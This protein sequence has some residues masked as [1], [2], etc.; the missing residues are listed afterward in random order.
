LKYEAWERELS[1]EDPDREFILSGIR[2]G[3]SIIDK[4]VDIVPVELS[5]HKSVDKHSHLYNEVNKQVLKELENNN[6]VVCDS[7]PLIVSPLG[8]IPKDNNAVRLIHDCSLPCGGAVND[9]ASDPDKYSFETMDNVAKLIKPG[10][11]IAK[12]DLKSAYRS[13]QIDEWSQ[14]GLKWCVNGKDV[15]LRDTKLPFGSKLGPYLQ[16]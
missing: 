14:S 3:F 12:L 1:R 8:A 7:K 2:D 11:Y 10:Y 13:V 4:D 15:H 9:Y 16:N 5:N 6:Y